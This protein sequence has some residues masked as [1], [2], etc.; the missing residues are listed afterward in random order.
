VSE[1]R[2]IGYT[3]KVATTADG[4]A[5]CPQCS[6]PMTSDDGGASWTCPVGDAEMDM[7]RRGMA[8]AL[9]RLVEEGQ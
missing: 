2:K 8:A 6:I 4:T 5:I 7:I 9:D 3:I 1:I